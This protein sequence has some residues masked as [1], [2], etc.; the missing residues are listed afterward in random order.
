MM[1]PRMPSLRR[2]RAPA[3]EWQRSGNPVRRRGGGLGAPG[4]GLAD[5]GVSAVGSHP[6][7]LPLPRRSLRLRLAGL[8]VGTVAAS[9]CTLTSAGSL[10]AQARTTG[11]LQYAE[12]VVKP[13]VVFVQTR[14][15][16][17]LVDATYGDVNLAEFLSGS[18]RAPKFSVVTTCSAWVA[19]S[20]GYIV[21]A[22]HA[23]DNGP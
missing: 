4:P 9:L 7:G 5:S 21:T 13:S 6:V 12:A 15:T 11:D 10:T 8:P 19:N 18:S 20:D 17:Y 22:G 14:W 16:G 2:V 1:L 23:V 3:D